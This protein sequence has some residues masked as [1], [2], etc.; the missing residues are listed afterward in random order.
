MDVENK[1]VGIQ[2]NKISHPR[3][4]GFRAV[5]DRGIGLYQES[6]E[7]HAVPRPLPSPPSRR[8]PARTPRLR[9]ILLPYRVHPIPLV[10]ELTVREDIAWCSLASCG[11]VCFVLQ[12][13]KLRVILSVA[14]ALGKEAGGKKRWCGRYIGG[15]VS[16]SSSHG[17][18]GGSSSGADTVL[19]AG[20]RQTPCSAIFVC[21]IVPGLERWA[22]FRLWLTYTFGRSL[23]RSC[24]CF[25]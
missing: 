2:P 14:F 3:T 20:R 23:A 13:K 7:L 9:F 6:A 17:G 25:I 8:S 15:R 16:F 22:F 5:E 24:R 21:G 10:V 18:D 19:S 11:G 12:G 1:S 4:H